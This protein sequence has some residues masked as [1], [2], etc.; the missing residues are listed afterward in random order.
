MMAAPLLFASCSEDT[1]SNPTLDLSHVDEGFVLNT[2]ANAENNTYDLA[3]AD[4]LELTCTQPNYGQGVP[5]VVNYYVQV[6][7]DKNFLT[8]TTTT[9]TEL[10]SKYTTAKM[11]VSASELNNALVEMWQSDHPDESV[12]ATN[13]TVSQDGYYK[14]SIESRGGLGSVGRCFAASYRAEQAG[15]QEDGG[16]GGSHSRRAMSFSP[17]HSERLM[18]L[19]SLLW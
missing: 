8:D 6:A 1:D 13:N 10:A 16:T 12:I 9:H 18:I 14:V 11:V 4:G 17:R 19:R 15:G 3:N 2:P 5:Y 7:I